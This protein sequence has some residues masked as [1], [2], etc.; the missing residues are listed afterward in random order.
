MKEST[1]KAKS[2]APCSLLWAIIAPSILCWV[3]WLGD[4]KG[5]ADA[6]KP[7]LKEQIRL[8]EQEKQESMIHQILEDE[9]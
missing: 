8:F 2:L 6:H 5:M 9:Q 3:F 4:L 1:K 7:Q